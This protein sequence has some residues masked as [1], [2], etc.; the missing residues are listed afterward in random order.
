MNG[1]GNNI[2]ND[3]GDRSY[4]LL[5]T[6]DALTA[7]G[8]LFNNAKEMKFGIINILQSCIGNPHVFTEEQK[9]AVD[10]MVCNV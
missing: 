2:A 9:R 1:T 10:Y 6:K 7:Q 8:Y 4:S 3:L 5:K